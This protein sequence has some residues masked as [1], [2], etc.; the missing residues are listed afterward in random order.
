MD[1]LD[2]NKI[3]PLDKTT[4]PPVGVPIQLQCPK[5]AEDGYG[6][7]VDTFYLDELSES[8]RAYVTLERNKDGDFTISFSHYNDYYPD[9]PVIAWRLLPTDKYQEDEQ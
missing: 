3:I 4:W 2:W 8:D 6:R 5:D 7:K 9:V 1:T